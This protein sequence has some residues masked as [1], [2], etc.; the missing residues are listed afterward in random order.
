VSFTFFNWN[1]QDPANHS[2]GILPRPVLRFTFDY[3]GVVALHE[4]ILVTVSATL[5]VW[6]GGFALAAR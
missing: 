5:P 1:R 6:L 3:A 2:C 4:D